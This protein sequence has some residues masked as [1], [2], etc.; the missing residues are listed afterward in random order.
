MSAETRVPE[1]VLHIG[2]ER[3]SAGGIGSVLRVLERSELARRYRLTFVSSV[4]TGT[5]R[6]ARAL[7]TL[8]FPLRLAFALRARPDLAHIHLSKRGSVV[9]KSIAVAI[10]RLMRVPYIVHVHG[11]SL[12]RWVTRGGRWRVRA[13]RWILDPA[14]AV[15][16]VA[17]TWARRLQTLVSPERIRVVYN[18]A[19]AP[20][21]HSSSDRSGLLFLGSLTAAKGAYVLVDALRVLR[22]QGVVVPAMLAGDGDAEALRRYAAESGLDAVHVPG[23]MPPGEASSALAASAAFCLPSFD[24]GLPM[25]L[26]EAMAAGTPCV[27]TSVGGIPDVVQDGI[28]GLLVDPGDVAG[29]AEALR[30]V[31]ADDAFASALGSA[32]RARVEECC[33][34]DVMVDA[35]DRVY[36]GVLDAVCAREAA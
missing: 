21:V 2:P 6:F 31:F 36:R 5:S 9:R 33:S 29:L 3:A 15:I 14:E 17:P 10:L 27:A 24:E 34:M 19:P 4:S 25:S 28:S 35:L 18:P 8:A 22:E 11:G 32:G 26:L 12:D 1:R 23:W 20:T 30:R 16:A 13:V 7:S